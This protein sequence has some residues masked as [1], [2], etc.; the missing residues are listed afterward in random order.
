MKKESV[1]IRD[2]ATFEPYTK[3]ER[4]GRNPRTKEEYP[5]SKRVVISFIAAAALKKELSDVGQV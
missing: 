5:I 3:A 1:K 2:F 4:T